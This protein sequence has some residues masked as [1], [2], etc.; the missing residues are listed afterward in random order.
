[1][2]TPDVDALISEIETL[3]GQPMRVRGDSGEMERYSIADLLALLKYWQAQTAIEGTGGGTIPGL[4]FGKF[5][6]PGCE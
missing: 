5:Q 6:P 4:R 2:A 1:M 3:S